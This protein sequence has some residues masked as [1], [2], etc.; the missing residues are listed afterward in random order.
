M[1]GTGYVGL[2]TATCLAI[3]GHTVS[4]HD[5]DPR[6]L[7]AIAAGDLPIY[8]PGLAERFA[9]VRA[10]GRLKTV[11]STKACVADADMVFLA[12]G[13]PPQPD[14]A[15]DLSQVETAAQDVARHMP[16]GSILVVK[17]TV[18]V[19]T[20]RRL[21][22][23]VA[24]QRGRLDISVASNPEFLREGSAIADFLKPDR[25]VLGA[26]DD[27]TLSRLRELY[28]DLEKRGA[29]VILTSTENAELVKHAAN[30][31]LAL[32]IGFINDVADLCE[33]SGA[34]VGVV[35]QG[36]GL[37][38]RIGPAFL[39]A[40]PGFGG[41]CFPKDTRAF[42]A[43]ARRAGTP[44]PLVELLIERNDQRQARLAQ[45]I[46]EVT[47]RAG[48]RVVAAMGLAFKAGTDDTRESPA[49][50]VIS[51]LR[52][53]GLEVRCHDPRAQLPTDERMH[54]VTMFSCPYEAAKGADTVT[55]LTEW[56]D[57]R[58]L[59]LVRLRAAMRGNA[60]FDLRNLLEPRDATRA[61]FNYRGIGRASLGMASRHEAGERLTAAE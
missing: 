38:R 9:A 41:S 10:E 44:Q 30:S 20:C 36:I 35:A 42:A 40:G 18:A 49:V 24:R 46:A 5:R 17:S 19:G 58:A 47:R 15:I 43:A 53:R 4:C 60:L 27:A 54:G 21:R 33:Q 28:V 48:G 2:T 59:D 25:I 7:A 32:K 61:G 8:E 13:T 26:D 55:L 22:Q 52:A 1:I 37:D 39:A 12:V 6:R 34:D 29:P 45:R 16:S 3:L 50:T 11:T 56:D 31:F 14:G 57:Y 51:A 23:I